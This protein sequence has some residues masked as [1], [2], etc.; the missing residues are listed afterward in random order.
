MHL[1]NPLILTLL[2]SLS[3]SLASAL[4]KQSAMHCET[5]GPSTIC[6][7]GPPPKNPYSSSTPI[8]KRESTEPASFLDPLERRMV[9]R[10]TRPY[11]YYPR[12]Q[13]P[14]PVPGGMAKRDIAGMESFLDTIGR[15]EYCGPGSLCSQRPRPKSTAEIRIDK[16]DLVEGEGLLDV[17]ERRE[18]CG[19]GTLCAQY[20]SHRSVYG[21]AAIRN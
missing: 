2:A 9:Y 19:P 4:P 10:P 21:T 12:P 3:L 18:Y 14:S 15:R 1:S 13:S 8:L 20:S 5:H 7:Q 16:R 17:L 11:Y 6:S